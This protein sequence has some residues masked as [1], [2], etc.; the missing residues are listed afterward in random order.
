MYLA[1]GKFCVKRG[2]SVKDFISELNQVTATFDVNPVEIG[3]CM[4][5]AMEALGPFLPP[6]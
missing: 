2:L 1:I 4:I 6:E 5:E 3:E